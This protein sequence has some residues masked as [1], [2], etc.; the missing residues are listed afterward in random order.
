MS[1]DNCPICYEDVSLVVLQCQHRICSS[2][3]ERLMQKKC[4]MCRAPL[5]SYTDTLIPDQALI[6]NNNPSRSRRRRRRR[7]WDGRVRQPIA[8]PLPTRRR[9][10]WSN[11]SDKQKRN[12]RW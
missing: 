2:C 11:D 7:R 4:P 5:E 3:R 8:V 10:T 6:E 12:A 9:R 1:D